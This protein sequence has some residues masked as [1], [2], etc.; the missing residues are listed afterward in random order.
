MIL[1]VK[2]YLNPDTNQQEIRRIV[3]YDGASTSYGS[4]LRKIEKVFPIVEGKTLQLFWKG[5]FNL[6]CVVSRLKS[7]ILHRSN[8][9]RVQGRKLSEKKE[10]NW[11]QFLLS[12]HLK[13]NMILEIAILHVFC[14]RSG[15]NLQKPAK[16]QTDEI[17]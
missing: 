5:K 16:N 9:M 15:S 8:F 11:H 13:L 17:N 12:K 3:L 2:V 6:I 1:T 4:L 7:K 14:N 10:A